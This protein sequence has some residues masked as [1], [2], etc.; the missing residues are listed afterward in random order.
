MYYHIIHVDHNDVDVS[1][2]K[3]DIDDTTYKLGDILIGIFDISSG[4]NALQLFPGVSTTQWMVIF[5]CFVLSIVIILYLIQ[6]SKHHYRSMYDE[7]IKLHILRQK[8]LPR[9]P[10]DYHFKSLC[11]QK[12]PKPGWPS[13]F[14]YSA[15]TRQ[16]KSF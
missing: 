7:Q 12:T 15:K 1:T 16:T 9:Q 4:F 5:V 2:T 10:F 3:R 11:F 13:T 6:T 14:Y 8:S